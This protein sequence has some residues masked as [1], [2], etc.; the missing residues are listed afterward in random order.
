[1]RNHPVII[2]E[3]CRPH[4]FMVPQGNLYDDLLRWLLDVFLVKM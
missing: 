4:P 2:I 1:V 3:G